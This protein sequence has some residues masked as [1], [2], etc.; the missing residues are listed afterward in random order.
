MGQAIEFIPGDA[1]RCLACGQELER[2]SRAVVCPDCQREIEQAGK[3]GP[4]YTDEQKRAM[5]QLIEW[6]KPR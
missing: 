1:D 4:T 2:G 6:R 5:L 3:P